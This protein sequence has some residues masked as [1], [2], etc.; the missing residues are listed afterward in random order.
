MVYEYNL[1][2]AF[3]TLAVLGA[4]NAVYLVWKH[5]KLAGKPFTC[6]L[7][8]KCHIVTDS[9]WSNIFGIRN[10]WLGLLYYGLMLIAALA[11]IF[12]A[13]YAYF[14]YLLILISAF[15]A[16]LFSVFLTYLQKYVIK[17][18]CFYCL[19]SAFISLLMFVVG[20]LMFG[21]L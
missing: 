1:I 2:A 21:S 14:I 7:N 12:Y 8:S 3:L 13:S 9:K 16:L 15:F 17:E 6:P 19:I 5:H 11:S 20:V 18:Y 10:E 4:V